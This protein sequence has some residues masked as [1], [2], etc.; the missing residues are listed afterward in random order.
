[1]SWQY[2]FNTNLNFVA[3]QTSGEVRNFVKTTGYKFFTFNGQV[4]DLEGNS[5]GI[6][7]EELF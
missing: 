6:T 5:I 7:A 4:L 1:M 2:V 3:G